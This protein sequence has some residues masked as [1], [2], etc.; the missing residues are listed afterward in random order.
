MKG[1]VFLQELLK[2]IAHNSAMEGYYPHELIL[3]YEVCQMKGTLIGVSE[4]TFEISYQVG[5]LNHCAFGH[6]VKSK[7]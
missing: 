2:G 3:V 1:N 4:L 6:K 5:L 7:T